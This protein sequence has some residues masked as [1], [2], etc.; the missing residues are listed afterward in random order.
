MYQ[1]KTEYVAHL[2]KVFP[3]ALSKA[4][5]KTKEP[6]SKEKHRWALIAF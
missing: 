4:Q 1:V 6:E 5:M 3:T 2:N